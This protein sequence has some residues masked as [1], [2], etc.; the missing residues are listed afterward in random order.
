MRRDISYHP[1]VGNRLRVISLVRV[2]LPVFLSLILLVGCATT[3]TRTSSTFEPRS[4][5]EIKFRD[6]A[7]TRFDNEVRVSAAVPTEAETLALFDANLIRREIQPIW[8][9]VENHSEHTYYLMSTASDPNYFSPLEAAYAV[10]GGL[11]RSNREKLEQYFRRKNFRNPILPN[12]AVSGF[13]FTN[14][15]QGEKVVQ[16]TLIAEERVKFFTFFLHKFHALQSDL[17]RVGLRQHPLALECAP[18]LSGRKGLKTGCAEDI[19][20]W[21]C[22]H[23]SITIMGG[24]DYPGFLKMFHTS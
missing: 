5:N 21:S 2:T 10:S 16:V 11:D 24:G 12:T 3:T 23:L 1:A 20:Y 7:Q 13:I 22:A 14:L 19:I 6:R 17:N 18:Y 15:D 9:Q 4:M 8:V